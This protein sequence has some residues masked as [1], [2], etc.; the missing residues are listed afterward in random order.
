MEPYTNDKTADTSPQGRLRNSSVVGSRMLVFKAASQVPIWSHCHKC[1][2]GPWES[3]VG[4]SHMAL[5]DLSSYRRQRCLHPSPQSYFTKIQYGGQARGGSTACYHLTPPPW[6]TASP[7]QCKCST[8]GQGRSQLKC[9]STLGDKH[10][11]R[12]NGLHHGSSQKGSTAVSTG[13]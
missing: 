10:Q 1:F 3:S 2:L 11:V 13:G 8:E 4:Q 12:I 9:P 6:G 5:G 7:L